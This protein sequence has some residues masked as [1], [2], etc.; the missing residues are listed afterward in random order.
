MT[1]HKHHRV[2]AQNAFCRSDEGQGED[3]ENGIN[4]EELLPM[5][6]RH[7]DMLSFASRL[8]LVVGRAT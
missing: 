3:K 6:P 4:R 7:V 2:A 5:L 1:A 8:R